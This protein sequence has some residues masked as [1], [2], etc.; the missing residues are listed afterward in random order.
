MR[1]R[2]A[3][4][5]V[6]IFAAVSQ[7]SDVG[8]LVGMRDELNRSIGIL[9]L[10]GCIDEVIMPSLRRIGERW[11]LGL[12]SI[13][14]ERLI[15]ETIRGWLET[16]AMAAPEPNAGIG[17]VVLAC[18]PS[19]RH[20]VALEALGVLLRYQRQSCRVLGA[21]TTV[22]A[23]SIAV[24]ANQPRAVVIACHLGSTQPAAAQLLREIAQFGPALFYAG[25]G[26]ASAAQRLDV[27]GTY[28]GTNLSS[29]CEQIVS[30]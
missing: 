27:P 21:R 25:N 19:D 10:G 2:K 5:T 17:P 23:M 15:T 4:A 24:M 30:C 16:L 3:Q 1:G 6:A 29:A 14:T 7:L 8:D 28:L 26:F 12:C 11:Q 18:G 9:G 13:D 22:R 20:T